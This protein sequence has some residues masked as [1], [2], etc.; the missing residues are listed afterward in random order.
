MY[1]KKVSVK[2]FKSLADFELE[3]SPFTCLIGLNGCGKSTVLQFFDFISHMLAGDIEKWYEAREWEPGD[4]AAP[5]A[6]E[7][8]FSLHFSDHSTWSG[9]YHLETQRCIEEFIHSHSLQLRLQDGEASMPLAK[10]NGAIEQINFSTD[11]LAF[12]GSVTNIV[13]DES[14]AG[15][16]RDL[17]R[18][19]GAW[20]VFD[21]LSPQNLRRRDRLSR[22]SIGYGGEHLASYFDGLSDETR[23][24]VR[25]E[26][27]RFY[28]NV[29]R[30]YAQPL[31]G[32][33]KELVLEEVF[34][35]GLR[36]AVSSR[37]IND[38]LLRLAAIIV[39]LSSQDG[40]LLFDEIEN[41]INPEL[42]EALLQKLTTSAHQI[43]VTTHSPMIL[44][45]LD[46]DLARQSVVFLYK[47][48]DGATRSKR[49]FEISS[50][51]EKLDVMGPGEAFVDTNLVALT[52]ELNAAAAGA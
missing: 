33:W 20:R 47:G 26:L 23:E 16:L 42:I 14:M 5:G 24:K 29:E 30:L 27:S 45:Y 11:R 48:P 21:T 22:S 40:F 43:L 4:I 39:E 17:K 35:S 15:A 32:G 50:I 38:G 18:S 49:F 44:N 51:S 10:A 37:H 19:V 34:E 13:L 1:I 25:A 12:K 31:Q 3:L 8:E 36:L 2:G 52:E 41:G 9:R 6:R 28:P 7:I 46:D